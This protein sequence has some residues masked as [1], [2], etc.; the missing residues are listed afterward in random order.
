MSFLFTI[1][2]SLW[3]NWVVKSGDV[4]LH[5]VQ[6]WEEGRAHDGIPQ[7]KEDG[8][9]PVVGLECYMHYEFPNTV[10]DEVSG[11]PHPYVPFHSDGHQRENRGGDRHALYQATH[12]AHGIVKGPPCKHKRSVGDSGLAPV[13]TSPHITPEG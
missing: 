11:S 3:A 4:V 5:G 9:H 10:Q 7:R 12:F 6:A 2:T 8:Q 13:P 1:T